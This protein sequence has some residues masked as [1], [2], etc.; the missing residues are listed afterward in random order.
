MEIIL[1]KS[2]ERLAKFLGTARFK[3]SRKNK[4]K[5]TIYGKMGDK[6]LK[7]D[8]DS[9]G[10]ELAFC[11]LFNVYPDMDPQ[12]AKPL[13]DATLPSG[14]TVDVKQTS[15][16][17]GHLAPKAMSRSEPCDIYALVI[18]TVPHFNYVGW[19]DYEAVFQKHKL[20]RVLNGRKLIYPVY[21]T[22]QSELMRH[23]L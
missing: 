23:G 14:L 1:T 17:N 19:L 6:G 4:Y 21:A 15:Y 5:A 11:R 9:M 18:G 20:T 16:K 10:A 8:I 22:P 2:E 3:W 13:V 7:N 12:R